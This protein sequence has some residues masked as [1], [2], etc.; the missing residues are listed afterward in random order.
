MNTEATAANLI[1]QHLS[2][3]LGQPVE[4]EREVALDDGSEM[5]LI[6]HAQGVTLLVEVKASDGLAGLEL[7]RSHVLRQAQLHAGVPLVAVPYMGGKAREFARSVNLSWMDLSGN[8]DIRGPGLRILVEGQPNRFASP[9]RPA[10]TFSDR[11]ARLSR[12][13]LVEPERWWQQRELAKTVGISTGYVSKVVARLLE[14]E[15]LVQDP[16]GGLR[17][18][19]PDLLLDAW[20][21]TYDFRRHEIARFH[22]VGRTGP[23]VAESLAGRLAAVPGLTWAATGLAAAWACTHFVDHRLV[24]FFV[25]QPLLEPEAVGLRP[26]SQGENVWLAVPRDEGVFFGAETNSGLH[27]VHP[28]QTYLDLLG[29]PERAKE[30]AEHLRTQRLAWRKP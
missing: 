22:A 17:P 16:E 18:R 29:H 3:W 30:A 26:V 14:V 25:S 10:T 21:Q 5:D 2:A 4:V 13:M 23:S 19:S 1:P 8:A 7:A 24:T 11:A 15:L 9:G 27:C 12:A 20:A 6:V 28:V